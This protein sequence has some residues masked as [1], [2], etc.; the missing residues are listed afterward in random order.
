MSAVQNAVFSPLCVPSTGPDPDILRADNEDKAPAVFAQTGASMKKSM[1]AALWS[2]LVFPGA[3]HFLLKRYARGM[4][5]FVP[6]VLA[7]LYLVNDMLQ[8]AA[9][10]ADKI[11]SGAVPADVTAIT[12]L[13][14]AG[15]KDSTMLELAGYVLLV[16]WVAGMIDS[17]RIGNAEDRNDEKKL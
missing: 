2:A 15:G 3:G 8:Q 9:V 5:L 1:K 11:M 6:T 17:Y 10:I 16:C 4:V 12:A 7:L 14:A 13:V